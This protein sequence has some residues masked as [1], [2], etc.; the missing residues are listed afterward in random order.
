MAFDSA[1][2]APRRPRVGGAGFSVGATTT[3]SESSLVS[4]FLAFLA[5]APRL[6]LALVAAGGLVSAFCSTFSAAAVLAAA[7]RLVSRDFTGGSGLEAAGF[8]VVLSFSLLLPLLPTRP[9]LVVVEELLTG[10]GG[11]AEVLDSKPLRSFSI[12]VLMVLAS[13]AN[14]PK[15]IHKIIDKLLDI[16]T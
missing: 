10:G 2:L 8:S 16:S 1:F 3:F 7:F 4:S 13:V 15:K 5:G 6:P 14:S 12:S 9:F 11:G